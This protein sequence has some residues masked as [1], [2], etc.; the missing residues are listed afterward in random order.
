M[1]NYQHPKIREAALNCLARR[2]H[3]RA[4]LLQKLL[5]RNFPLAEIE[6]TLNELTK[7]SLQSD[8]RFAECYVK[9]RAERGFGPIHIQAELRSRGVAQDL[10]Q[11]SL[12][13]KSTAWQNLA[14]LV[15]KKKFGATLPQDFAAKM[16]QSN[17]LR[18]KGFTNEQIKFALNGFDEEEFL[19]PNLI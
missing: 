6:E 9:S 3:A 19:D 7:E 8:E 13:T 14:A 11:K 1:A 5:K 2:E 10:I 12:D 4:E 15:R 18:Y 16:K 17:F